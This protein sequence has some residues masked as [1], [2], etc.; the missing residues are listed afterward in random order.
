MIDGRGQRRQRGGMRAGHLAAAASLTLFLAAGGCR[1]TAPAGACAT[2]S[3]FEVAFTVLNPGYAPQAAPDDPS[4]W[5]VQG[6]PFFCTQ[7]IASVS[8]EHTESGSDLIVTTTDEG[9]RALREATTGHV[10]EY[11]MFRIEGRPHTVAH[12]ESPMDVQVFHLDMRWAL[13]TETAG[14][15]WRLRAELA[16]RP[17]Q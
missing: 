3:S 7:H 15:N 12:L 2:P 1:R 8:V 4:A 16:G 9:R 6:R 11:V 13:E 10:G 17:A 14:F 5:R